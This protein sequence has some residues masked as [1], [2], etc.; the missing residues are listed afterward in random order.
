MTT[1]RCVCCQS[2]LGSADAGVM[3]CHSCRQDRSVSMINTQELERLRARVVELETQVPRWIP[4]SERMPELRVD[5]LVR[6]AFDG[7]MIFECRADLWKTAFGL[8][9]WMFVNMPRVLA[10]E[11]AIVTHWMPL[12]GGTGV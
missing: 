9:V 10:P 4:C 5:V 3:L 1:T 2:M 6:G 12:P 11:K 8:Q 7:G